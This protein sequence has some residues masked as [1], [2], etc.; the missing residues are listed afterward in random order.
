MTSSGKI[1]TI[2]AMKNTLKLNIANK[3]V[4]WVCSMDKT[5]IFFN[6]PLSN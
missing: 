6:K 2:F 1:R 3:F 4:K 5:T